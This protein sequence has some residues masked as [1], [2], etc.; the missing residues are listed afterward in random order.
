MF[1]IGHVIRCLVLS[2]VCIAIAAAD[3]SLSVG[4]A[5]AATRAQASPVTY[6]EERFEDTNFAARG[7]YDGNGFVLSS[8]EHI[9]G[10]TRSAEFRWLR[11]ARTPG[12]GGGVRRKFTASDSVYVSYW[13]KYSKNYTGS[14]KPYHPHEFSLLTTKNH[15]WV[16]PAFTHLTG[17]I[18]QN[19]GRPTLSI[20]DGQNIDQTR[21][22]QDLTAITENRSV[23]GCNGNNPDGFTNVDCY[24]SGT[25][26]WN[27]KSGKV[28]SVY[29][30]DTPG[31]L[32]K[33]D[34]HHVAAFFKMNS[35]ANGKGVAD[36]Q[37]KYWY[38]GAQQ[39]AD[40]DGSQPGHEME[41]V[42]GR[43]LHRRRVAG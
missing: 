11:G 10:S 42:P 16:G 34:W 40:A 25:T 26:Y 27:G 32:Y 20:Q 35:I 21:I 33:N 39:C 36:G 29:F 9:P 38:D 22:G 4:A 37:L 17:Y 8:A 1:R 12:S 14:N 2:H 7:W 13:V 23:A 18:E 43:A 3:T 30:Q 19:E 5:G 31:P 24:R 6:L 41:S 28:G 15:D